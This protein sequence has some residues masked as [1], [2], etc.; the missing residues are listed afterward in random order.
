MVLGAGMAGLI[1]AEAL[2]QAGRQVVVLDKGRGVGG[3][4]ATRRAEGAVFDHGAQFLTART[5]RWRALVDRWNEEG[6]AVEWCR[7]F[8]GEADGHPR[9]R[10]QPG[11]T[12]LAKSLAQG[13]DVRLQTQVTALRQQ[14]GFWNLS[15]AA[16]ETL[17]ARAVILTAP[18]PQSLALLDAGGVGLEAALRARLEA[19]TYER[20]LVVMATLDAPSNVPPPGGVALTDG[21]IAWIGDNQQKGISAEPALTIQ[22]SAEY[23]LAN[24]DRPREETARELLAAAAPWL[25]GQVRQQQ[26]HGWR[27]SRPE[28][29][30]DCGA[31]VLSAT[32]PLIIAGDAF[33]G[34][35]I[36][37]AALSGRAAA[38]QLLALH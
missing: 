33:A 21:P 20:C 5:L 26:M 12:A 37:G 18:V 23:S 28:R 11:M 27:Y 16:S 10:G 32:P 31:L 6:V 13:L 14:D 38:E 34:A 8:T 2:Q 29:I 15:T 19:I 1:A 35:R 22:A 25:G 36:E 7:G 17:L 24:W 30:D 4:L 9:W 3:R